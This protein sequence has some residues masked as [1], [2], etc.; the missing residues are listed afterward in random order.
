MPTIIA[1][2]GSGKQSSIIVFLAFSR[3]FFIQ[4]LAPDW[5]W[6]GIR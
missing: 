6:L 4:A 1:V 2:A 5:N 3:N